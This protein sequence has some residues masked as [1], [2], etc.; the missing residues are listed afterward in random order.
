MDELLNQYSSLTVNND[1]KKIHCSLTGH[2]MQKNI[3]SIK[4]YV[5]GKK[6]RKA[7]EKNKCNLLEKYKEHFQP[8]FR[9]HSE[10]QLLCKI[11]WREFTNDPQHIERHVNGKRF[12]RALKHYNECLEKGIP[13][14]P[15][16]GLCGG[17]KAREEW[18]EKKRN[19]STKQ[20]T[21][22]EDEAKST[23]VDDMSDLYP[24]EIEES[25]E[26]SDTGD[27]DFEF[28]DLETAAR[29][30]DEPEVPP[31]RPLKRQSQPDGAKPAKKPKTVTDSKK[32][33]KSKSLEKKPA[34]SKSQ[35]KLR[36]T[37]KSKLKSAKK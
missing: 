1:T 17:N 14:K 37:S 11:T 18:P 13:F 6:F 30:E 31:H 9:K 24:E 5:N 16:S 26:G 21:S 23:P 28:E 25:D 34:W 3:E 22:D 12:K 15:L 4:T 35:H 29:A 19:F 36:K 20:D 7:S 32:I 8:S 33:D 27:S 10:N 2:E